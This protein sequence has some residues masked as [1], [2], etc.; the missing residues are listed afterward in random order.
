MHTRLRN[1]IF[2]SMMLLATSLFSYGEQQSSQSTQ[3]PVRPPS[4]DQIKAALT[5]S[6]PPAMAS[7]PM[8]QARSDWGCEVLMCMSNPN[9]STAVNECRPPMD[10]L[11]RELA[12]GN[13]FPTC[14]LNNGSNSRTAGTWVQPTHNYYSM[15]PTN[16]KPLPIGSYANFTAASGASSSASGVYAGIGDGSYVYPTYDGRSYSNYMPPLVCVGSLTST[17]KQFIPSG[18]TRMGGGKWIT[19]GAYSEVVLQDPG[20]SPSAFDIYINGE[21]YTRSRY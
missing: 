14:T 15:C 8:F 3:S 17:K 16:T 19:V 6:L 9:G 20:P 5:P 1:P 21:I 10:R 12:R 13:S 11:W 2:V 18:D 4:I 7:N